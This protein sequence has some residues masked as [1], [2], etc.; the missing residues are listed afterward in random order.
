[1][2][3]VKPK[4]RIQ[5]IKKDELPILFFIVYLLGAI[6][7]SVV[8]IDLVNFQGWIG[9]SN[10]IFM[11]VFIIIFFA[12]LYILKN[13]SKYPLIEKHL[14][15][16]FIKKPSGEMLTLGPKMRFV[17]II[18]MSIIM[19][20]I[21]CPYLEGINILFSRG[22]FYYAK[23]VSISGPQDIAI[24]KHAIGKKV[25]HKIMDYFTGYEVTYSF[26]IH[27][28]E[29]TKRINVHE[30]DI[31]LFSNHYICV[32]LYTG[33]LGFY[34]QKNKGYYRSKTDEFKSVGDNH[35]CSTPSE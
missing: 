12:F 32:K 24:K 29:T 26:E 4:D 9:F 34:Y 15:I 27:G 28:K 8:T 31:S 3:K 1:M 2:K 7:I 19:F 25:K 23:I 6:I 22:D 35:R 11:M 13:I 10:Y 17:I 33:F 30:E 20:V 5:L 18:I 14:F 16:D 21:T